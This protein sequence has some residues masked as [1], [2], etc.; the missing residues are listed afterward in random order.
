M[1]DDLTRPKPSA[2]LF[3]LATEL[4]RSRDRVHAQLLKS[5]VARAGLLQRDSD[6]FCAAR[7]DNS[8][9]VVYRGAD[10]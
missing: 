6:A 4:N 3:E 1:N 7:S 10:R 8:R 5:L 2:V 9:G